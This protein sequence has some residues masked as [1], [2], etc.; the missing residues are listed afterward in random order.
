MNKHFKNQKGHSVMT[1]MHQL[2]LKIYSFLCH[3]LVHIPGDKEVAAKE[4]CSSKLDDG[5]D[6]TEPQ[7]KTNS[8]KEKNHNLGPS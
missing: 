1:W 2:S 5:Y 8:G 7:S 3:N 6:T 4:I